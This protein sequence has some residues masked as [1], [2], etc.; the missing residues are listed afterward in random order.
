L[1]RFGKIDQSRQ[2]VKFSSM[3][4]GQENLL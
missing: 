3:K 4:N 1:T 2:H